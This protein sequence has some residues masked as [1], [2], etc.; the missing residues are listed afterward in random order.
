MYNKK[1]IIVIPCF[2]VKNKILKVLSN[3]PKWIYKIVCVDDS[4]PEKTGQFINEN[5]KDERVLT[6]FN[7]KNLGVGGASLAGFKEAKKLGAEIIVK[8]DGDG[9]MDINLLSKFIDPII[10]KDADFTK[11]NRFTKFKD[12]LDMPITRKIGNIF[13]SFFNRLSSGYWNLFDTTNGYL[14]L[15]SK[16]IDLLPVEKISKDYFFESD[17]LNWLY[18]LR[19]KVN[20]VPIKSIY[21]NEK[22]NINILLVIIKFPFLYLRNFFRRFFYEYCLRNPDMKF[23][24]FVIGSFSLIF[25]ILFS[26]N[27][28]KTEV[29]DVPST[30]GTVG[31]A[32]IALLIGINF[33]S[34][35]FMSDLNNYPKKTLLTI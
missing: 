12:Y 9:Q 14:C 10:S 7:N 20:D 15:N 30:S 11:G 5:N 33:V 22:S 28:W 21:D 8:I 19:A 2:Q 16:L 3:V 17:L 13:L 27:K 25:G 18:I 1:I 35:F 6:I 32:M 34:F 24:S 26:I 23:I 29:A 4:C 31:I